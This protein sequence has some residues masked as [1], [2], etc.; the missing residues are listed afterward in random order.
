MRNE[1]INQPKQN[2]LARRPV[3]I[4]VALFVCLL[5]GSAYPSIVSSYRLLSINTADVFQVMLFA[6][7]RFMIAAIL[8]FIYAFVTKKSMRIDFKGL[9][10]VIVLGMLQTFGQY[11]FF[12]L[13]LRFV[14]PANGS[15]V[16]S[17]G[18]F[19]TVI[20]AHFSYKSDRLTPKKVWGFAVGIIGIIILNGGA[21]STFTFLGE[22]F[23]FI[24]ALLG[25]IAGVYTKKLTTV[26]SPYIITGYQLLIGSTLLILV[27]STFAT[28]VS[29]T[30]TK[31]STTLLFY[32]GFV[33]AAAFTLW[34]ALLK[35]NKV[36]RVSI[37]RFSIP[38]FSVLLSFIFLQEAFDVVSV[39]IALAFVAS[40]IVLINME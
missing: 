40:G 2:I 36:S 12:F 27:G 25:A 38:V 9:K 37:Y 1:E 3:M 39:L 29:F 14:H 5:W 26:L 4:A 6:G 30:F 28:D 7:T 17:L 20:I 23:L 16:S 13:G 33:S 32:L 31:P 21:A 22:G 18:I 11:I 10:L 15:I 8:I 24:A 34:S 19:M 35:H